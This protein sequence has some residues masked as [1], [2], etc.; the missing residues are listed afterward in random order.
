MSL[1]APGTIRD[2]DQALLL[3][4]L[5]STPAHIVAGIVPDH[6]YLSWHLDDFEVVMIEALSVVDDKISCCNL[7]IVLDVLGIEF[8]V[9]IPAI[10]AH[11]GHYQ[12]VPLMKLNGDVL[13]LLG[14]WYF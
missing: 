13:I 8:L 12:K 2:P 6:A 10:E 7:L 3:M 14:N 9:H 5:Y 4:P 1:N 11:W